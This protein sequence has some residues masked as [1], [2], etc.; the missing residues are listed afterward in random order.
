MKNASL[1]SSFGAFSSLLKAKNRSRRPQ[2]SVKKVLFNILQNSQEKIC[3][4]VTILR[5][6]LWHSCFVL[7]FAKFLRTL[8]YITLQ[9]AASVKMYKIICRLLTW[10]K[11]MSKK[12]KSIKYSEKRKVISS[13]YFLSD[14]KDS[15]QHTV[16]CWS[17]KRVRTFALWNST[18]VFT[19]TS[20]C[21]WIWVAWFWN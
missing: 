10:S 8:V 16:T 6:R 11:R 12:K 9:L 15:K 4:I 13:K 1:S 14:V 3:A 21:A 19:N 20:I 2:C 18:V 17:N 5:K 7:N